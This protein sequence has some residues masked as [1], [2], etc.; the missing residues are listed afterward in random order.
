MGQPITDPTSGSS[1]DVDVDPDPELDNLLNGNAQ[2]AAFDVS[3]HELN[4]YLW[5]SAFNTY[6]KIYIWVFVIGHILIFVTTLA[7]GTWSAPPPPP[8]SWPGSWSLSCSASP[9]P[10]SS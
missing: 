9:P 4:I 2:I 6:S 10:S 7:P 5:Y 8:P 1:F 3:F